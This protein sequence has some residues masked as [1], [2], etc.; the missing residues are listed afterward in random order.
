M[1]AFLPHS[2]SISVNCSAALAFYNTSTF[3]FTIYPLWW[4]VGTGTYICFPLLF[5]ALLLHYHR[6]RSWR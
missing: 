6:H 1:P 5:F 3:L 2:V 4:L